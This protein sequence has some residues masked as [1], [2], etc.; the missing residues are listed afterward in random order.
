MIGMWSSLSVRRV[1]VLLG[2]DLAGG[3]VIENPKVLVLLVL[4]A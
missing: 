3:K 2:N 1:T 4:M